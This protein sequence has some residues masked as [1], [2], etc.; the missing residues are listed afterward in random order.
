MKY[1]D[2]ID[3][4]AHLVPGCPA[5]EMV[6]ALRSAVAEFC[7]RSHV[8]TYWVDKTSSNLTFSIT[9]PTAM[10]P[11][12]L[13][14]AYVEGVEADVRE[15]NADE[16]VDADENNRMVTYQTDGLADTLVI[17][18]APATALP[19]RL[20]CS[21]MPHP[22]ANEYPDRLWIMRREAIK[23]GALYRLLSAPGTPY[24][25]DGMAAVNKGIFDEAV[26]A[27]KTAASVNRVTNRAR[28]RVT[29]A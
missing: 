27:A 6:E 15:L 21:Y 23:A 8:L 25:N 13:F 1:I 5:A 24:V 29:P 19:V 4:I 17:T 9:G 7:R 16:L 18:P 11:V 14:Q 3:S 22:D 28:L 12:A 26:T 2:C 20:L 10:V